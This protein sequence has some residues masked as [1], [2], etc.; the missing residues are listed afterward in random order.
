MSDKPTFLR[1]DQMRVELLVDGIEPLIFDSLDTD[2]RSVTA[3]RLRH[4]DDAKVVEL[5]AI[6]SQYKQAEIVAQPMLSSKQ[7][8][9]NSLHY[10][11]EYKVITH[12]SANDMPGLAYMAIRISRA[13][14]W[15]RNG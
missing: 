8:V 15:S 6:Y 9:G 1:S 12:Y 2:N 14:I 11:G 7:D 3:G 10:R 5:L 13:E 4:S